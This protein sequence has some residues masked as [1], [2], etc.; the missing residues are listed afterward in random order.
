MFGQN[1]SWQTTATANGAFS[2]STT[3]EHIQNKEVGLDFR[4]FNNKVY[5]SVDYFQKKNIGMLIRGKVP[6]V[7]GATEPVTNLGV[8]KTT[9]WEVSLGWRDRVGEFDLGVSAN[10]S[11]TRNVLLSYEGRESDNEN[12]GYAN[13]INL[14]SKGNLREG[15]SLNSFY[16]YKTD[17]YFKNEAEVDAYYAQ[18]TQTSAG[19]IPSEFNADTRLRPGD[20]KVVDVNGDNVIDDKDL[21]YQGDNSA[22]YV[23]GVNLNATYKNWDLS[24][25]FQG[26]LEQNVHRTGYLAYPFAR[27]YTKHTPAFLGETWTEENPNAEFPR[28]STN[29][30]RAAWN[31]NYN[32]FMI[33]N[34]AYVRLKSLVIGYNFENLGLKVGST[35]IDK[36]RIYFSGNDLFELST[37]DD[38]YDPESTT[39]TNGNGASYP[40]MRTWAFGVK[41]SL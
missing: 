19:R 29:Y 30:L 34:N 33:Q 38:G 23:F 27:R 2:T 9:G 3:W 31:Y 28:T 39:N 25:F 10:M 41:V 36:I 13:G 18:Y 15:D 1:A 4:L 6:E 14:A 16:M 11:D 37:L 20:I 22:H 17:G 32:N 26:S 5:G 24:A 12:L 8:M 7:F 40:F 21:E 35:D